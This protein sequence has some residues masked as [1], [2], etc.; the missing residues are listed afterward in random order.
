M[1]ENSLYNIRFS[2]YFLCGFKNSDLGFYSIPNLNITAPIFLQ[3][4]II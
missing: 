4:D 2:I 1:F 3:I